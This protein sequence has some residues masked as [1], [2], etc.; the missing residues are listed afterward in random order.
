M[1]RIDATS[2]PYASNAPRAAR[3]FSTFARANAICESVYMIVADFAFG[4]PLRRSSRYRRLRSAMRSV[5]RAAVSITA[6]DATGLAV[7]FGS[8][9]FAVVFA[10]AIFVGSTLVVDFLKRFDVPLTDS[11]I[12]MFVAKVA[13]V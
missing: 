9:G 7:V 1:N 4:S 3:A 5:L 8:L 12:A 6:A 13:D 10:A 11:A 2:R